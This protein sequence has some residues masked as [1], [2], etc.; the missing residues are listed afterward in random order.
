MRDSGL[1]PISADSFNSEGFNNQR[2]IISAVTPNTQHIYIGNH[3][4]EYVNNVTL[5]P[6]GQFSLT[7]PVKSSLVKAS[8]R[9]LARVG[10]RAID[11]WAYAVKTPSLTDTFRVTLCSVDSS[12][13]SGRTV[14]TTPLDDSIANSEGT[15]SPENIVVANS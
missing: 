4:N 7:A 3:L 13:F 12:L 15:E 11:S 2:Q 9:D 14:V 10:W 6:E 8:G 5:V 1:T